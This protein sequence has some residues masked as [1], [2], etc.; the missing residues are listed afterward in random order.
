[1]VIEEAIAML[2]DGARI[3]DILNV[4]KRPALNNDDK[5]DRRDSDA[6]LRYDFKKSPGDDIIK[7]EFAKQ[8]T[9]ALK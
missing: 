8:T 2:E 5:K 1:M 9:G 4:L 3:D 6:A 7:F